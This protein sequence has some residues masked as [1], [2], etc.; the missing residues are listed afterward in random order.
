M[1]ESKLIVYYY[2]GLPNISSA[3]V[4]KQMAV[5]PRREEIS[6]ETALKKKL[7]VRQATPSFGMLLAWRQTGTHHQPRSHDVNG[8]VHLVFGLNIPIFAVPVPRRNA[9]E[10][11]RH[12]NPDG[13]TL[14]G[15]EVQGTAAHCPT[16]HGCMY[17]VL[18]AGLCKTHW[19]Q[20]GLGNGR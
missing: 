15:Q 13:L 7:E 3:S 17:I 12:A 19:R 2:P 14:V 10:D 11:I 4:E 6:S 18:S 5:V 8:S 9:W 20:A 16:V 1:F